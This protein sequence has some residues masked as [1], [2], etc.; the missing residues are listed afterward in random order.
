MKYKILF[1]LPSILLFFTTCHKNLSLQ[2]SFNGDLVD[3]P[4][5]TEECGTLF[6]I[7]LKRKVVR[8]EVFSSLKRKGIDLQPDY[9]YADG[10]ISFVVD[11][12]DPKKKI[13]YIWMDESVLDF[14]AIDFY[15]YSFSGNIPAFEAYNH[16]KELAEM[17][18]QYSRTSDSLRVRIENTLNMLDSVVQ[19]QTLQSIVEQHIHEGI[20][21]EA[22]TRQIKEC[23]EFPTI[24]DT[25][26]REELIDI[27][28]LKQKMAR[29]A[30]GWN[31]PNTIFE[32][33]Y[34]RVLKLENKDSIQQ[35]LNEVADS[36]HSHRLSFSE[37]QYLLEK[38]KKGE[39]F[40]AMINNFDERYN[41][42]F[43]HSH[44]HRNGPKMNRDY[45]S[46]NEYLQRIEAKRLKKKL[47]KL[48]QDLN[49]YVSWSIRQ[50]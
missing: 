25:T 6:P 39:L 10:D 8:K 41:L 46:R 47:K 9:L 33:I 7:F 3:L 14:D 26:K 23:V 19:N 22:T 13:G 30:S 27:C 31:E 28:L 32:E 11:G 20:Y 48:L 38:Q 44:D 12:F 36:F 5:H 17:L 34:D 42:P 37:A 1:L 18:L 4:Y 43:D 50:K 29:Y 21:W 40:I 35:I 24:T 2:N 45:K 49:S 15:F 16:P